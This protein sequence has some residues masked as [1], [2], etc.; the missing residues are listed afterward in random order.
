MVRPQ[1]NDRTLR[2]RELSQE[3]READ[4]EDEQPT[5]PGVTVNIVNPPEPPKPDTITAVADGASKVIAVK[6]WMQVAALAILAAVA[7]VWILKGGN[8]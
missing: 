2:L 4:F 6:S 5:Q 1:R 8:P 7:V 3:M